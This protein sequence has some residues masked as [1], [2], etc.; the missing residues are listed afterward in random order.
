MVGWF[1]TVGKTRIVES[2]DVSGWS[3]SIAALPANGL[4]EGVIKPSGSS[5]SSISGRGEPLSISRRNC[6]RRS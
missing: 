6:A 3:V 4:S 2:D 1:V 5:V